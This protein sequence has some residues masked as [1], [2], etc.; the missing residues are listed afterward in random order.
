VLLALFFFSG[1]ELNQ[2]RFDQIERGRNKIELKV[3]Q[4]VLWEKVNITVKTNDLFYLTY[5]SNLHKYCHGRVNAG[6]TLL[7]PTSGV[8]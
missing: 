1:G 8:V 5:L 2:N 3:L 6:F 4:A 7:W